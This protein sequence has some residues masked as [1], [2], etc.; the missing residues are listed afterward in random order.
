MNGLSTRLERC[1]KLRRK[2]RMKYIPSPTEDITEE[3]RWMSG[4]CLLMEWHTANPLESSLS[5]S[6]YP[7]S[8]SFHPDVLST[9]GVSGTR[10]WVRIQDEPQLVT[11]RSTVPSRTLPLRPQHKHRLPSTCSSAYSLIRWVEKGFSVH[12]KVHNLRPG[13]TT[14]HSRRQCWS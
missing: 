5:T 14:S 1:I 12:L 10:L 13:D 11:S 4:K 8:Q 3:V 9:C 6:I 7:I 2:V